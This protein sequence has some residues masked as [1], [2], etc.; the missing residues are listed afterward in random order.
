M[1]IRNMFSGIHS[2]QLSKLKNSVL[3]K[4]EGTVAKLKKKHD[5]PME[6][7]TNK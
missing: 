2:L 1:D 6:Y 5:L 7:Q 4:L 3:T